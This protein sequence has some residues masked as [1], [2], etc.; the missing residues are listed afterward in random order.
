MQNLQIPAGSAEIPTETSLKIRSKRLEPPEQ[1][2][3]DDD[4]QDQ[5]QNSAG[6]VA[7]AG[8]VG[9]GRQCADQQQDQ[10]D[11][12]NGR[13]HGSLQGQLTQDIPTGSIP[14]FRIL[15]P[16]LRPPLFRRR[17]SKRAFHPPIAFQTKLGC[18]RLPVTA[19]KEFLL[20]KNNN[21]TDATLRFGRRN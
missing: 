21:G 13:E 10:D 5:S 11:D 16:L 19:H 2:Q 4:D 6:P 3:D 12:Q 8:A 14:P 9:P 20:K 1:R 18:E 7:P 17:R 15:A